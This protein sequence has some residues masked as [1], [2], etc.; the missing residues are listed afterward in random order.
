MKKLIL[1]LGE[2]LISK[3]F[4]K[5]L[6]YLLVI[7]SLLLGVINSDELIALVNML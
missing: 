3:K 6:T 5:T 4:L 7:I 1:K 2:K